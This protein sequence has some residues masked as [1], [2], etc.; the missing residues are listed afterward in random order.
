MKKIIIL[1]LLILLNTKL[2]AQV[3]INNTTPKSTFDIVAKNSDGST[4][5]GI[6]APRLTGEQIKAGDTN[7]TTE[8]IGNIIYATTAVGIAST[9][10]I[11]ITSP[12]YYY[13]DGTIWQR[14]GHSPQS[15]G[16]FIP[17]V[18]V[19][20]QATDT[21][22]QSANSGYT[23]WAFNISLNDSSWSTSNNTYTVPKTGFYQVSLEGTMSPNITHSNSF[24]W[25]LKYDS[26]FYI[27]SNIG[28]VEANF[29]YKQGGAIVLFFTEGTIL[30]FGGN[31]CSSG[32]TSN[33]SISN[34][35]FS[36]TY[37]GGS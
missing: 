27:F 30:E 34:R 8:Q 24:S 3:G 17:L 16:T 4:P 7:Y 15:I 6:I 11:N 32:C 33:Y 10:T 26:S 2:N 36:I 14:L 18:V 25:E 37:L 28:N 5:E 22:T 23:K 9:K 20:G 31:V 35:S 1:G 29:S 12:G 21:F 13:F 19:A